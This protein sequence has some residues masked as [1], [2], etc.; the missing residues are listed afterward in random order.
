MDGLHPYLGIFY[1]SPVAGQPRFG[2]AAGLFRLLSKLAPHHGLF[3][4]V[5]TPADI[6]RLS[7]GWIPGRFFDGRSWLPRLFPVPQVIYDRALPSSDLER[8]RQSEARGRLPAHTPF[9]NSP[10]LAAALADKWL[11]HQS[12]SALPHVAAA[13]PETMLAGSD[14]SCIVDMCKRHGTVVIKDRRGNRALGVLHLRM[15]GHDRYELTAAGSGLPPSA[16]LPAPRTVRRND[17]AHELTCLLQGREVLV[18]Q[19]IERAMH[20]GEHG[21]EL[22]VVMHRTPP[23]ASGG[24][25][26]DPSDQWLRTGMVCRLSNPGMPFLALG[27][28]SDDRPSVVLPEALGSEAAAAACLDDTRMLAHDITSHLE[29]AFGRGGELAVDFLVGTRGRPY[30]LEANAAPAMLFRATSAERLRRRGAE[31]ILRYAAYLVRS[32]SEGDF[33]TSSR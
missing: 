13:L 32:A 27:Q 12:L 18:Q 28:E 25:S 23:R 31:R 21:V 9:V 26:E 20:R 6:D 15:T 24:G 29:V 1:G 5:L 19:G 30:F 4:Y 14:V 2:R 22:R 33:I 8:S 10:A 7:G 17:L 11:V 16:A 3:A